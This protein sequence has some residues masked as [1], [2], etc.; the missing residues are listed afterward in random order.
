MSTA[1]TRLGTGNQLY[2][3]YDYSKIF[4]GGNYY[5]SGTLLE[6]SSAETTFTAGTIL[7][8]ITGGGAN[9]GKLVPLAS[10]ATD[11]SQ[12]PV[13]VLSE[14]VTLAA[15][16][17]QTVSFCYGGEIAEEKLIFSGSDDLDVVVSS[18]TIGDRLRD[19][20]VKYISG[21]ELSLSDNY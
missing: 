10:A 4:I 5:G 12:F 1:T 21:T 15:D 9:D 19:L 2:T 16:A 6:A 13:G 8:R 7:G 11:G 17:E 14:T 18:R 3:E 20:G